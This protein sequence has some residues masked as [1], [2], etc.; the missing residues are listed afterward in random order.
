MVKGKIPPTPFSHIFNRAKTTP[1]ATAWAQTPNTPSSLGGLGLNA[2]YEEFG[3]NDPL[4]ILPK[5]PRFAPV[6]ELGVIILSF[7]ERMGGGLLPLAIMH[8]KDHVEVGGT[9]RILESSER[10]YARS[11]AE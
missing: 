2:T 10:L 7:S 4:K 8:S 5:L 11:R 6:F 3:S 9:F 1:Y